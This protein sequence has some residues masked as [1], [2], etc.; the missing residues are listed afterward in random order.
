[1]G[2][3]AGGRCGA[4]G[5]ILCSTCQALWGGHLSTP[6]LH[7]EY[8]PYGVCSKLSTWSLSSL[9]HLPGPQVLAPLPPKPSTPTRLYWFYLQKTSQLCSYLSIDH[10]P[11]PDQAL[12][13]FLR[14]FCNNLPT[15]RLPNISVGPS[16]PFSTLQSAWSL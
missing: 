13:I 8:S 6:S 15:S 11:P 1:M 16:N 4:Q 3:Q 14:N 2:V 7:P 5:R 9:L 10:E 12:G